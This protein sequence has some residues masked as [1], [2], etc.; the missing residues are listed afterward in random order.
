MA[1]QT[2]CLEIELIKPVVN[3]KQVFHEPQSGLVEIIVDNKIS[4]EN[5]G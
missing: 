5:I 2:D 1:N 3:T 4:V